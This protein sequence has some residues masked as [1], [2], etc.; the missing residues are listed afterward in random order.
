[1]AHF[2]SVAY[3]MIN[4]KRNLFVQSS[5]FCFEKGSNTVVLHLTS[6]EHML[7]SMTWRTGGIGGIVGLDPGHGDHSGKHGH[8]GHE[9]RFD[10]RDAA[11][12]SRFGVRNPS[13]AWFSAV[14]RLIRDGRVTITS[15][16]A[17]ARRRLIERP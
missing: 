11:L 17:V 5:D 8:D 3:C 14:H 10:D 15:D 13:T 9:Q 7:P 2:L 16:P 4:K 1:M 6:F 12:L